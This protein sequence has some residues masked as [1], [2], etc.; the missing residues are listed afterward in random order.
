MLPR[1]LV[2]PAAG[3]AGHVDKLRSELDVTFE[4]YPMS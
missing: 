2:E 3:W 1:E 4:Y